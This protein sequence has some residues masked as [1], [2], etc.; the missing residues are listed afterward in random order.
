M[1][2]TTAQKKAIYTWREKNTEKYNE[3]CRKASAIY[4]E[5]HKD[6]KKKKALERYYKKK[7]E[8]E[9]VTVAEQKITNNSIAIENF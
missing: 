9:G 6:E 2:I 3:L 4:Y 5:K 7:Q 1:P 8:R